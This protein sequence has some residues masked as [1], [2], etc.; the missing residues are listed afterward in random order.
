MTDRVEWR[1]APEFAEVAEALGIKTADI[2]AVRAGSGQ[3]PVAI[4]THDYE[5]FGIEAEM[6]TVQLERD[7]EG[8]LRQFGE[9][10]VLPDGLRKL[11]DGVEAQL[12]NFDRR[13]GVDDDA[14]S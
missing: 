9:P 5:T 7:A 12:D 1:K 8:I 11:T 2:M 10:V 6:L 4:Y 13:M 14:A 3:N